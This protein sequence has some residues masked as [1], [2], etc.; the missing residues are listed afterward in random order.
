M[1]TLKSI[2][3]ETLGMVR[4]YTRNTEQTTHISS[5]SGL[6]ASATTMYVGD[7][8]RLSRGVCEID[9]EMIWIDSVNTTNNTVTI[10]PYGRG[11]NGTTAAAHTKNTRVVFNPIFS[12]KQVTDAINNTLLS[13]RGYLYGT[14]TTN[15]TFNAAVE[16][17]ALPSTTNTV[18]RVEWRS[19]GP[20]KS[21]IR[22]RSWRF[23]PNADTDLFPTGKCIEIYDG[24]TP[25]Q[26]VQVWLTTDIQTMTNNSDDFV[27]VT[28]LPESCKDLV[29]LGAASRLMSMVDAYSLDTF[30]AEASIIAD[31]VPQGSG[32]N[33]SKYLYSLFVQRR[34]DEVALQNINTP[35]TTHWSR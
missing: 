14:D 7:A 13:L 27:Y 30:N 32:S 15:F 24:I 34:N 21:Y 22:A 18:N 11:F 33:I 23:N 25:G 12:R 6:S 5:E 4:S 26:N 20:T 16:A 2:I 1:A 28:S 35:I 3:D 19:V 29:I 31:K 8:S 17:Y 9:N 10:A